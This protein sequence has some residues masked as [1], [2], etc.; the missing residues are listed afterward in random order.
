MHAL[1]DV[2]AGDTQS[3]RKQR[4]Q[5]RR[6][7]RFVMN[8]LALSTPMDG[9]QRARIIHLCERME[10]AT[11]GKGC[12]NGIL[13]LPAMMILR[14]LLMLFHN[15][16]TGLCCPSYDT[17]QQVTGLCRQSISIALQ[18]L[19]SAGVLKITRRMIRVASSVGGAICQ[20]SSN[21][22]AFAEPAGQLDM[23]RQ[24][25]R[26]VFVPDL[27]STR[28]TVTTTQGFSIKKNWRRA[29]HSHRKR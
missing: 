25:H 8:P 6:E 4:R 23:G 29:R 14:C 16:R 12:R 13:G 22:Y 26:R 7:A 15:R 20:Q 11:K 2:L 17:L 19:E 18:R 10:R 3:N 9:N 1:G 27:E 24:Q 28:Q 5:Y 21:L